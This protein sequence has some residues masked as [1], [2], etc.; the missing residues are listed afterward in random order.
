M[1]SVKT[2][3]VIEPR[4]LLQ[5]LFQGTKDNRLKY[6]NFHNWKEI[7][8][9]NFEENSFYY[10]FDFSRFLPL[11]IISLDLESGCPCC[12]ISLVGLDSCSLGF[13][14]LGRPPS[15]PILICTS[16]CVK[17]IAKQDWLNLG[18]TGLWR[19]NVV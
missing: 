10:N 9:H 13:F 15:V 16:G 18:G 6:I 2:H 14:N 17:F 3:F 19:G 1:Y 5:R 4:L 12:C 8:F 11:R 7:Y